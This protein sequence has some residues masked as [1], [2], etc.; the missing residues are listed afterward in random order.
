M[1]VLRRHHHRRRRSQ[2]RYR[3][4]NAFYHPKP[5]EISH[6]FT[7]FAPKLVVPRIAIKW[8]QVHTFNASVISTE[9]DK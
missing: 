6:D 2:I 3:E 1:A 4:Q 7:H 8:M 9:R 5:H